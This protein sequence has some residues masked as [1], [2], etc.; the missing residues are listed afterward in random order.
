MTGIKPS[1]K[2]KRKEEVVCRKKISN[3]TGKILLAGGRLDGIP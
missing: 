1:E 3:E 2:S